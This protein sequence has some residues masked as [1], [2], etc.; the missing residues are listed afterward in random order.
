MFTGLVQGIAR[1]ESVQPLGESGG[2]RIR[3]DAHSVPGFCAQVGDSIALNGACL[4]ATQ[5]RDTRF[6]A[7]VSRE[8]LNK[9]VGLD[10]AG[11]VNLELSLRLGDALGGHLVSGHVD[12]VGTVRAL[13]AVGESWELV[14]AFAPELARFVAVKGSI[15]VNGVSLTVNRVVDGAAPSPCCEISINLIPHTCAVT[16]LGQLRVGDCVNLEID[17]IARYVERMLTALPMST[18]MNTPTSTTKT[19]SAS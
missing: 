15:V 1:I 13:H 17:L 12:G 8:T 4:T 3:V 10:Q 19:E 2:V 5:V 7:E 11:A 16:T 18:P 6:E 14:L 9:T